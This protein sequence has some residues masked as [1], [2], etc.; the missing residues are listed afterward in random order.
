MRIPQAGRLKR[1]AS[2]R[3]VPDR[4]MDRSG[5]GRGGAGDRTRKR[6]R[7]PGWNLSRC[8][9][10][11]LMSRLAQIKVRTAGILGVIASF[12]SPVPADAG[13]DVRL[14]RWTPRDFAFTGPDSPPNPF[15]VAF[16][17]ELT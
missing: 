4:L 2:R 7:A 12:L 14:A 16:S 3:Q 8:W 10:P 15:Q 1:R 6:H 9:H 5:A 17:A 13:E 11:N